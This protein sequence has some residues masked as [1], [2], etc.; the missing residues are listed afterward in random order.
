MEGLFWRVCGLISECV[1]GRACGYLVGRLDVRAFGGGLECGQFAIGI[2]RIEGLL[3]AKYLESL[4]C[5]FNIKLA[6]DYIEK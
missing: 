2:H 1:C 5:Y 4:S 6:V 3:S